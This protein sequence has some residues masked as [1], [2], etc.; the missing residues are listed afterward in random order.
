MIS[1]SDYKTADGGVDWKRYHAAQRVEH[2][3]EVAAGRWCTRCNAYLL[4]A[5]GRPDKCGSCKA[6]D[7]PGECQHSKFIRCPACGR[8]FDPSE[9]DYYSLYADGEH[10]ITCGDCNHQYEISTRTSYTFTSPARLAPAAAP[11]VDEGESEDG[12]N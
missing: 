3:A 8:A 12:N 4:W 6:L 5:K 11:E 2:A 7:Q 9:Q 10:K 1:I